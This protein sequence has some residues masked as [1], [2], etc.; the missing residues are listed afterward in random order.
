MPS[1]STA[2]SNR[3]FISMAVGGIWI[4]G[5]VPSPL[6]CSRHGQT[7][8]SD[9]HFPNAHSNTQHT[10]TFTG[11]LNRANRG[12]STHFNSGELWV[13]GNLVPNLLA[14]R[15]LFVDRC[16]WRER[17]DSASGCYF[18]RGRFEFVLWFICLFFLSPN[19]RT[20]T[21][22]ENMLFADGNESKSV[23]YIR[24]NL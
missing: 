8:C 14:S 3:A 22:R 13:N 17:E 19:M 5:L 23:F 20:K 6:R 9:E 10:H 24:V 2:L 16:G 1:W 12:F 7:Y 11:K 18:L 21:S 4:V 15:W